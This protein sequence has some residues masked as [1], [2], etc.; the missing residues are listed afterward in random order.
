MNHQ[1]HGHDDIDQT[2]GKKILLVYPRF[3]KTFWSF[4]YALKFISK[5]SGMTPLGLITIASLLPETWEKKLVDLNTGR[6]KDKD[7]IWADYV[8][9]S[10]MDIQRGICPGCDCTLQ[11]PWS[12]DGCRRS[13][14][15]PVTK[16]LLKMWTTC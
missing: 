4:D 12:E 11:E 2:A 16:P 5:K 3:P 7:L 10:A 13:A 1:I 8:F 6:L 15:F 14:F 9:I